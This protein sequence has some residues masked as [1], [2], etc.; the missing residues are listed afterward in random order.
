MVR[1]AR[2]RPLSVAS[3][4]CIFFCVLNLRMPVEFALLIGTLSVMRSC[5]K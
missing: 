4:D 5:S 3:A 1:L 2:D